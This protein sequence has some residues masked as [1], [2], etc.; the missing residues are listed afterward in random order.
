MNV[1]I[2]GSCSPANPGGSMGIGLI[3]KDE[4][5]NTLKTYSQVFKPKKSNT[6]NIA[7][8][9]ALKTFFVLH[10]ETKDEDIIIHSD[11]E[12]LVYQMNGD[13]GIRKGSYKEVAL[14]CKELLNKFKK[15]NNITFKWIPR[16][17]NYQADN[18]SKI[19]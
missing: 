13:K 2:D 14:E 15:Y 16:E 4:K 3:I 5:G 1:F 8:Y 7:E 9:M 11:S 18:L 17:E 6:N 12:L 10:T 19:R